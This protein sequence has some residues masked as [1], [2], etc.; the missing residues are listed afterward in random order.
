MPNNN[1]KTYIV[2]LDL[3]KD[4]ECKIDIIRRKYSPN[5]YKKWKAHFTLKYEEKLNINRSRLIKLVNDFCSRLKPIEL[6]LG[7]IKLHKNNGWNI[8]VEVSKEPKLITIIHDLSKK[9]SSS[10]KQW[11]LTDKF[12]PHISLKGGIDAEEGKTFFRKIISEKLNLPTKISCSSITL[13]RWDRNRWQKVKTFKLG[14]KL[15]SKNNLAEKISMSWGYPDL[16]EFPPDV[17]MIMLGCDT[18]FFQPQARALEILHQ[19]A[20]LSKDISVVTKMSLTE[21]MIAALKD[22]NSRLREHNNFLSFSESLTS[23]DSAR[24]WEPRVPE[25]T[26]RIETL[27]KVYGTGIKTF[28]ALRPLL[29]T[30]PEEELK[31]LVSLT[32]DYCYGYYS[33]PLYLKSLDHPLDFKGR[34]DLIIEDIQPH[35]M[36]EGNKF[37]RIEKPGQMDMLRK[38][39]GD[40]N[41]MLFEG[42]AEAINYWRN[43]D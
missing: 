33:G 16:K 22:V 8:H 34:S 17:K 28:V 23:L 43:H 29:P 5:N 4:V 7:K 39:I 37:Y 26:R 35:W 9:L 13:A 30:V 38:I 15:I 6:E 2:F 1:P 41:G 27:K 18:E 3:P 25:P 42:A 20:H 21:E 36:P 31:D 14:L 19:L 24:K 32:K 40:E 11:Q 10:P 12:Y